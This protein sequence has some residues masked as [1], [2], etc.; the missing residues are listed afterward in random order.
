MSAVGGNYVSDAQLL[1]WVTTQQDRLYGDLKD[2]MSFQQKQGEMT[3]DLA[4]IKQALVA[5]NENPK[6][7]AALA[8]DMQAFV[9]KYGEV[10]EFSE[11]VESV[12]GIVKEVKF[13]ADELGNAGANGFAEAVAVDRAKF[14]QGTVDSWIKALDEKLDAAGTNQQLGMLHLNEIKTTIDQGS[15]QTSQLLKSNNDT[16]SAIINNLA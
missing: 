1:A 5:A 2:S 9:D 3:S 12:Q 7:F 10:P 11:I 15:Q 16:T 8:E 13:R 6:Q 14:A 4:D